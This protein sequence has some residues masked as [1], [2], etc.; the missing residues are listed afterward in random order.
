MRRSN[1][2]EDYD[3][4]RVRLIADGDIA[5]RRMRTDRGLAGARGRLSAAV[6]R[7]LLE[8]TFKAEYAHDYSMPQWAARVDHVLPLHL[9]CIFLGRHKLYHFRLWYRDALSQYVREVLLDPRTLSRPYFVRDG[10]ESKVRRH[11]KGN[12]NYP[13]AIHTALTLKLL[14]RL[15][16]DPG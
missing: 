7:G 8:F 11:L 4:D 12:R 1:V 16:I 9:E 13:T 15:F 5:L 6:T 10:L 14:H 2:F 3:D